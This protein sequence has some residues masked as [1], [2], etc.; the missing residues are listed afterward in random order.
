MRAQYFAAPG[1]LAHLTCLDA[2]AAP[3]LAHTRTALAATTGVDI[4]DDP[5][6]AAGRGYYTGLCYSRHRRPATGDRRRRVRRTQRLTGSRIERLL[7]GGFGL[8]RLATMLTSP[9]PHQTN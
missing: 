5:D 3:I 1:M 6:R 9:R 8:D 4:I 7:I 2:A